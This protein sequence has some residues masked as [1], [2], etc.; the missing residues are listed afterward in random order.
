MMKNINAIGVRSTV[1]WATVVAT[2]VLMPPHVAA[3]T[4]VDAAACEGLASLSLPYTAITAAEHIGAGM[5]TP[6]PGTSGDFDGLPAFCRVAATVAPTAQSEIKMEIWM[7]ATNWSGTFEGRGSSGMGG[8]IPR[9]DMAA[10]LRA[11]Y[12]TA[13]SDTGHEGDA[14]FALDQP[15]RVIDF[16]YRAGHEV[17]V[18]AKALMA[19]YHG[20][21]PDF[22]FINGCGGSAATAQA[23][24]QRYPD[25]YDA[26][27]I[28]GF[29]D[30][31]HH[32]FFQMWNW[33][34]THDDEA[35][36]IPPEKFTLV[37]DAV[38]RQCDALDRVN[39][40][41]IEDPR[42][43]RFDPQTI[44]CTGADGLACLTGPQVEA[45]RKIYAGPSNPA[46]RRQIFPPAQPGS[47]LSWPRT[48]NG[49]QPFRLATDFFKYFVYK[50]PDWSYDARPVDFATDV[51]LADTSENLV[52]NAMD[53]D[54]REFVARGG[55][56]LMWEGWNDTYIPPDIAID[57]YNNVVTTIGLESAQDAVRLFM[58][59]G[60]EHCGW[61]G[62]HG[63]FDVGAELKRWV[64][65]GTPPE[66][67]VISGTA[68]DGSVR[69]RPL[70][71]YPQV[72][73]YTG[74]GSTD[75]AQNFVCNAP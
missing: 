45:V 49:D 74:T 34:A 10:S 7:P 21:G 40:G 16:G 36:Y 22:S 59:P 62:S 15:E 9:A 8:A 26:I 72:A 46:T 75:D 6:P 67:I 71:P 29:S 5:Y 66:R 60:K 44:Q 64:D 53:P 31:T 68:E 55:K 39:D 52:V 28:T 35:S 63:E 13:G 19:A 32:V 50:D 4:S 41:V 47:E 14:R 18:K 54:I 2:V 24:A 56:L 17:P 70:C 73:T 57:Y 42:I 11:G 27:A 61:E 38:L 58:V 48:T 25:D 20:S 43:C 69:T 12:T 23:A 37:H 30:K 1:L 33:G 3:Q 51:A 65:T